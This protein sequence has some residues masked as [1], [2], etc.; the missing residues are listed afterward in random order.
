MLFCAKQ[1]LLISEKEAAV[2]PCPMDDDDGTHPLFQFLQ[3]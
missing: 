3:A 2:A 1:D